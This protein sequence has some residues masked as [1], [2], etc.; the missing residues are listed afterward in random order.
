[1]S[2]IKNNTRRDFFKKICL[3]SLAAFTSPHGIS[4]VEAAAKVQRSDIKKLP[5]Q[6]LTF[7]FQ[8]DSITDGNQTRDNDWNHIMGHGYAYL[9]ASRLW[10]DNA[11][12]GL[13]FISKGVSGNK[14]SDLAARWQT[15]TL[16]LK[17]DVLNILIGINHVLAI[18]KNWSIPTIA[19][20]RGTYAQLLEHTREVLP[21]TLI[22]LCEPSRLPLGW[23]LE[24]PEVW[25]AELEPRRQ[26]VHELAGQLNALFVN[27]LQPF[28]EACRK[29]PAKYWIWDGV[30][31]MPAGHELIAREWLS[32]VKNLLQFLNI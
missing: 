27:L 1:M 2:A 18:V 7:L 32:V 31:P 21:D 19:E 9:I 12:K 10:Y 11:D 25:K 14:L 6:N 28:I 5:P 15:D 8:G 20:F 30:H 29:A 23:T 26:I 22:A 4:P 3:T 16:D 24:K 13:M 17:P